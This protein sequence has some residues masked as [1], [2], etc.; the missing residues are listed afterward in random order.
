MR[1]NLGLTQ[2]KLNKKKD[3]NDLSSNPTST[4]NRPNWNSNSGN[5]K[6]EPTSATSK[7]PSVAESIYTF[8]TINIVRG[9]LT[10]P[11]AMEV[12][13]RFTSYIHPDNIQT[14]WGPRKKLGPTFLVRKAVLDKAKA[15][16]YH[17]GLP[18][19]IKVDQSDFL[20]RSRNDQGKT[21]LHKV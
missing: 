1:E 6:R 4:S 5:N 3:S 7:T 13:N 8:I 17:S 10:T 16:I 20:P 14:C 2:L 11:R 9:M 21:T 19:D 12:I 18:F 15:F